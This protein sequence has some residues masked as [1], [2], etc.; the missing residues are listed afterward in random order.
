MD[1]LWWLGAALLLV[2]IEV[3]TLDLVLLMFAGG[4]VAAGIANALGAPFP[5][6]IVVFAVVSVLLLVS[7]RP[8]LLR[9]LR[10]RVPLVETNAAAQVGRLALVVE[11][12][13]VHG[14]RVKLSGEVWSA[15]TAHEGM[16]MPTGAE[17]R[18]MR[19][20]GATAVVDHASAAAPVRADAAAP[21][22]GRVVQRFAAHPRLHRPKENA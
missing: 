4:A 13:D 6:Q 18:V 15:R 16:L 10:D 17:V 20:D 11:D 9:H 19:I 5:V 22:P 3:V 21:S 8:W 7:I 2:A 1:W 12:V 14:G